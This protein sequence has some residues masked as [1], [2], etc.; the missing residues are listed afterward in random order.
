MKIVQYNVY[1]VRCDLTGVPGGRRGLDC[2]VF[3]VPA[4]TV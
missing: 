1:H 2:A 3:Y 4:N